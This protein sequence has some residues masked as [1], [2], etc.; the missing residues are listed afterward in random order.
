M[1][2]MLRRV[3]A[4]Q[5]RLEIAVD[6]R[7]HDAGPL[8]EGGAAEAVEAGLVGHDLDHDVAGAAGRGGEDGLNVGD[9]Q[10]RELAAVDAGGDRRSAPATPALAGLATPESTLGLPQALTTAGPNRRPTAAGP[11]P[12]ARSR[13]ASTTHV[14]PCLYL[15]GKWSSAPNR[16]RGGRKG[17]APCAGNDRRVLRTNGACP[18]SPNA[19]RA[20]QPSIGRPA[21]RSQRFR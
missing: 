10:R 3:L 7:G 5:E 12:R 20:G 17:T 13:N 19:N 9:L 18:L 11:R 16:G 8:G 6:G 21:H 1:S 2:S 15:P 14:G 4:D